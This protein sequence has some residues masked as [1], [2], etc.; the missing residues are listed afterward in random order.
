MKLASAFLLLL[1]LAYPAQARFGEPTRNLKGPKGSKGSNGSKSSKGMN[2]NRIA[3]FSVCSQIEESCNDDTETSVE[4]ITATDDGMTLIH[5]DSPYGVIGFI[6]ISDPSNPEGTGVVSLN[7]EP[8]S[9]A[10]WGNYAIAA[11][12][13]SADYVNTSGIL[14]A[15]DIATRTISKTWD[16]GGQPDSVAVSPDGKY[17]VVAIENERDEDLGDGVPPQVRINLK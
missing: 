17:I 10:V 6:D 9:V 4:I 13:T 11:V 16:L 1:P 5:S 15:I 14:V 7:G 3:T 8:T 2:F 12:N